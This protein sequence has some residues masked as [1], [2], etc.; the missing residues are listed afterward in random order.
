MINLAPP[1][2]LDFRNLNIIK[3]SRFRIIGVN[4]YLSIEFLAVWLEFLFGG[5]KL[6]GEGYWEDV[7]FVF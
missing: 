4:I 3:Q 1:L 6:I 5:F 2:W 7:V